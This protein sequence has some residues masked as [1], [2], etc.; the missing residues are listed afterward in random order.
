M[1]RLISEQIVSL[2]IKI[3]EK[4][5]I[6]LNSMKRFLIES[7]DNYMEG[8]LDFAIL[9]AM[10]AVELLLK[11]RLCLINPSLVYADIDS[12][13]QSKNH[14]VK[15]S[16]L[17]LRLIN[18]GINISDQVIKLI[19]KVSNWRNDIAHNIPTHDSNAAQ[20]TLG[21]LYNFAIS[22]LKKELDQDIKE[23]LPLKYF[24]DMHTAI[25]ELKKIIHEAKENAKKN[26]YS[27]YIH[28][29]CPLC[30][31]K[32]VIEIVNE[33]EAFCHLCF[34]KLYVNSCLECGKKISYHPEKQ[35]GFSYRFS[36]CVECREKE[37]I[38]VNT[39]YLS[40]FDDFNEDS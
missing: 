27:D 22:F 23:F 28:H 34:K 32:D 37:R 33:K 17:P 21:E 1:I 36:M 40:K 3:M 18:L 13:K 31:I 30:K 26:G 14:T 15:L 2:D 10:I 16:V 24:S 19:E 20:V 12:I 5:M 4:Y 29:C 7:L 38:Y 9:H 25:S 39:M 8:K 35:N 6:R 11:E